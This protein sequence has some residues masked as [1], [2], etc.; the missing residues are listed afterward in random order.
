MACLRVN[1]EWAH[2]AHFKNQ[3]TGLR[4]ENN[5]CLSVIVNSTSKVYGPS[6]KNLYEAGADLG[7]MN[8]ETLGF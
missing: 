3:I 8:L 7:L 4:L 1:F 5:K 6:I 2:W